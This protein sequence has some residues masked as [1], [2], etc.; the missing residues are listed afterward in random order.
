MRSAVSRSV[1]ELQEGGGPDM[2]HE[3]VAGEGLVAEQGKQYGAHH[4][5]LR[6]ALMRPPLPPAGASSRIIHPAA[7]RARRRYQSTSS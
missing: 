1:N 5:T 6:A 7:S 2:R 3:W 4:V